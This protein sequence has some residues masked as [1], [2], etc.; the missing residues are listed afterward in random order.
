MFWSGGTAAWCFW[1]QWFWIISCSPLWRVSDRSQLRLWL[2]SFFSAYTVATCVRIFTDTQKFRPVLAK[3][4][5]SCCC[6]SRG[7]QERS[8]SRRKYV[9][10]EVKIL[11]LQ[12][13]CVYTDCEDVTEIRRKTSKTITNTLSSS[14][15]KGTVSPVWSTCCD[16]VASSLQNWGFWIRSSSVRSHSG[17]EARTERKDRTWVYYQW[18]DYWL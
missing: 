17:K 5:Y 10:N 18:L 4:F 9:S 2:C 8:L 14:V 1:T 11:Q 6:S 15:F 13:Y 3:N 7:L 12:F 16:S